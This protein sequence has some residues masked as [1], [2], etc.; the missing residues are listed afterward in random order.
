MR[1]N[2]E[3][4][5]E[6]WV[7]FE[8]I[9][10]HQMNFFQFLPVSLSIIAA[11]VEVAAIILSSH[12]IFGLPLFTSFVL[13]Q[14]STYA[15]QIS[16]V[17]LQFSIGRNILLV[18]SSHD[19]ALPGNESGFYLIL[20]KYSIFIVIFRARK[21]RFPRLFL[22][23]LPSITY[24]VSVLLLFSWRFSLLMVITTS[25]FVKWPRKSNDVF[26]H[27]LSRFGCTH[28]IHHHR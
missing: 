8:N 11:L 2:A 4:I 22:L 15:N 27:P 5:A 23:P 16:N 10:G 13:G 20:S 24:C 25:C 7:R 18:T 1:F 28:Y 17:F 12:F 9:G 26:N 21:S 19:E 3:L 14:A 6:N